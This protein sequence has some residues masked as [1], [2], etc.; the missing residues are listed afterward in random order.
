MEQEEAARLL[1]QEARRRSPHWGE[2]LS[3]EDQES[4]KEI[5]GVMK[6]H[7]LAIKLTAALLARRSLSSIRDE[8]RRN[9]PEE[10]S[11]R[12]DVSFGSLTEGQRDL[13][14]RLAVFSSSM[15]EEAV[16]SICIERRRIPNWK[17]DLGELERMSFLDRIEISAQDQEGKSCHAL[18]LQAPSPHA[19]VCRRKGG[20]GAFGPAPAQ[21]GGVFP[22]ICPEFCRKFL[23]ARPGA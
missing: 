3:A 18:P 6:G 11:E 12:F 14:C 20:R 2:H 5:A 8:L 13:F 4:L 17:N 15:T 19:P 1:W 9:P 7:P 16:G 23:H 21:G 22:G 10:V